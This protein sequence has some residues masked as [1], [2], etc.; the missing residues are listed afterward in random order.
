MYAGFL[1]GLKLFCHT[2]QVYAKQTSV[3]MLMLYE[4]FTGF[5]IITVP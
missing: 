2:R 4:S 3:Q 5:L 1:I